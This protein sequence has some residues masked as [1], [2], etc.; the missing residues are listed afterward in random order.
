MK[1]IKYFIILLLFLISCG[2]DKETKTIKEQD[3]ER[4]AN[5]DPWPSCESQIEKSIRMFGEPVHIIVNS[6]T[7]VIYYWEEVGENKVSFGIN[8]VG[9]DDCYGTEVEYFEEL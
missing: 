2:G 9:K 7:D 4:Q 6:D 5:S 3:D 1:K 8:F